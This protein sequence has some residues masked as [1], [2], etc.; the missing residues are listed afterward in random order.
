MK[1]EKKLKKNK[2]IIIGNSI[3]GVSCIEGIREIDKDGEI[4]VFSD[5]N[6]FNYS[7]PLISYY[8]AGR[9]KEEQLNFR[10]ENFYIEKNV[11]LFIKTPV[12]KINTKEK[13]VYIDKGNFD[14]DYL[15]IG[16]GGSPIIPQIK[17]IDKIREGVFTFTK[18]ND[19]K[20]IKNFIEKEKIKEVVVLGGGLIGL[21]CSE[22]LIE[23]GIS[24]IIIELS[25]R[26]LPNTFDYNASMI[27]E[28]K[29]KEKGCEIIK[30]NTIEKVIS[31]DGILKEIILKDGRKIKTKILI[32]GVGVIPETK[33]IEGTEIIKNKGIIV[34]EFMQ[35]N[36]P[37]IFSG[38]D[39]AEGEDL[40]LNKK[41]VIAIWPVAARMGKIAGYNMVGEGKKYDGM[42]IMNSIE[43]FG[44]PTIS[45]GITNPPLN[46]NYEI[47]EKI[48]YEKNFYRKIVIKENKIIGAI[49]LGKIERVGIISGLIK[50]KIDVSSFKNLLID[51][52]FGLLVLPET[53]RK[54]IV[55]GE[56][57]E[58]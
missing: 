47:I 17:G 36:L 55:K 39:V 23:R 44:I 35:T 52:K 7:R 41:S 9:L 54:H 20:N 2:Y 13:I 25:D 16:T 57:I 11:K 14:F 50:N 49:Y 12:K 22:G 4:F 53:Y 18:L 58:V 51:D 15:F 1:K 28:N 38:G 56:G 40:I 30:R 26:I 48:D 46:E 21:K 34:N 33:I 45:F 6:I 31:K 32:I 29:L 42:F 5:E 24:V 37:F 3:A 19:A 27:I 10:D 8:L 43:F